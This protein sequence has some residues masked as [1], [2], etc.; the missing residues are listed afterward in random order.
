MVGIPCAIS[1]FEYTRKRTN[2]NKAIISSF[3]LVFLLLL[4]F[5][6]QNVGLDMPSYYWM[7]NTAGRESWKRIFTQYDEFGYY[8]FSKLIYLVFGDFQW[9]VV[10]TSLASLVP[11]WFLYRN[12]IDN[13]MFLAIVIFLNIGLFSIYFSAIRQ[14]IAMAFVVPAYYF[15]KKKKLILF[16]LMIV[17][18][19]LFHK[20]AF[21]IVLMYPV[22]H[23]RIKWYQML[24]IS[25][26]LIPLCI[27]FRSQLFTFF[28]NL[29]SSI[30]ETREIT[31]TNAISILLLLV[32]FLVFS[33]VI[34]DNS[35]VDDET[36]GLRN[37]L[38]LCCM[39]QVFSGVD[40]LVMRMNYY[41]LL[42]VPITITRVIDYTSLKN[43]KLTEVAL[44][45]MLVFF[46]AFYFISAFSGPG[47]LHIYPYQA[48]WN[49]S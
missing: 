7:Y 9:L 19:F 13:H 37:L 29:F 35:L 10:I 28:S 8:S 17:P 4:V 22:Y 45:A 42:F 49:V 26:L 38:I 25:A 32:I 41:F 34:P 2:A 15:T 47:S 24:I 6:S 48:F 12:N 3:F 18:A 14:V 43:K 33:F 27:I 36:K 30:Y 44:L 23:I 1:V 40:T 31:L 20:S 16:L 5:R 46:T 21:I 39:L 11:I